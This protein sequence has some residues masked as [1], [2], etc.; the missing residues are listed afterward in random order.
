MTTYYQAR[1]MTEFSRTER[2]TVDDSDFLRERVRALRLINHLLVEQ[3]DALVARLTELVPSD[4]LLL[5][6]EV[7]RKEGELG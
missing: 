2:I 1:T 5:K 3:C 7:K 4:P 6:Y